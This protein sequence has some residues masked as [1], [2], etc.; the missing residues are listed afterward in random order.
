MKLFSSLGTKLAHKLGLTPPRPTKQEVF[1]ELK[2]EIRRYLRNTCLF[3]DCPN[4]HSI[5]IPSV[6]LA[7]K[8]T[9]PALYNCRISKVVLADYPISNIQ[10]IQ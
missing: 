7:L 8:K 9:G 4:G 1:R 2:F 10:N 3:E 6:F 5:P